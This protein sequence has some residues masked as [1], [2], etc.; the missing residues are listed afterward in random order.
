[1]W[2]RLVWYIG[3]VLYIMYKLSFW[4]LSLLKVENGDWFE[5]DAVCMD[6][7]PKF[8]ILNQFTDFHENFYMNSNTE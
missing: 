4:F 1:M 6:E 8:Q 2:R 3:A 5:H 7:T